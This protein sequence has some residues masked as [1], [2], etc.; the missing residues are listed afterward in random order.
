MELVKETNTVDEVRKS[1]ESVLKNELVREQAIINAQDFHKKFSGNWFT[2]EQVIKKTKM[3]GIQ[4]V[5]DLLN[6]LCLFELCYRE[7]K[8]GIVKYKITLNHEA[9]KMILEQEL[10]ETKQK[11]TYLEDQITK[12]NLLLHN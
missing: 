5:H 8:G 11:L 1:I 9:K 3:K 12:I 7:D 2:V 4:Q 10:Q 6:L